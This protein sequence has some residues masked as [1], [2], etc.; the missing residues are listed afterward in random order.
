MSEPY[1][2]EIRPFG[3]NFAPRNWMF[4]RGQL[5]AI[6]SNTALFSI[7]GT[8]YGGNGTTNFALPDLQSRLAL[9]MGTGPGLS[10]YVIGEETGEE[11]H[12]LLSTE[13]ASHSHAPFTRIQPPAGQGTNMHSTPVAGDYLSRYNGTPTVPGRTWNTPPLENATTL[14][15]SFVGFAGGNQAHNNI[16]P[17]LAINYCICVSGVFPAR[18]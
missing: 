7:I 4:C 2:G 11:N 17:V 10:T 3:F 6:S 9:G 18:N 12:L 5:L 13:M 16:Q 15:P 8:Y 14:H 1:I